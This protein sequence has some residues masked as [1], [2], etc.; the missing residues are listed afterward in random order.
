MKEQPEPLA[1]RAELGRDR[2]Q[3]AD[4][5]QRSAACTARAPRYVAAGAKLVRS[6]QAGR[7]AGRQAR[8]AGSLGPS[9]Q[10]SPAV[11]RKRPTAAAAGPLPTVLY[12]TVLHLFVI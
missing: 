2:Q 8:T 1:T 9:P 5:R 12:C 3:I 11:P 6:R 4:S 10:R 7:Q